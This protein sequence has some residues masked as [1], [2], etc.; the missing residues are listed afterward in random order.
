MKIKAIALSIG[1]AVATA[2]SFLPL[3][4]S[5]SN[6]SSARGLFDSYNNS[7][8][9]HTVDGRSG[10]TWSGGQ[11]SARWNRPQIDIIDIQAPSLSVGCGGIDFF[12]GAFGLI[13]GDELA[14]IGRAIAQGATVY[15][16]KLAINSICS[17]CAAEMENVAS[18]LRRF[19][20][21]SRNA[22]E[23]TESFLADN[24]GA[25]EG[26]K[27]AARGAIAGG[28]AATEGKINS[29]ADSLLLP[30]ENPLDSSTVAETA[31]GAFPGSALERVNVAADIFDYMGFNDSVNDQRKAA[32]VLMT[33]VGGFSIK[34]TEAPDEDSQPGVKMS[35]FLPSSLN[36]FFIPPNKEGN[37]VDIA[38]CTKSV[39][40]DPTC[41]AFDK[42]PQD[43]E[44]L[45]NVVRQ[46]LA[47]EKDNPQSG[48]VPRVRT[49]EGLTDTQRKFVTDFRIPYQN[50][51]KM[52]DEY[53][54]STDMVIDYIAIQTTIAITHQV[55]TA[56]RSLYAAVQS[57]M[58]NVLEGPTFMK[59]NTDAFNAYLENMKG[60]FREL[61]S[62]R[63]TVESQLG[64]YLKIAQLIQS[65]AQG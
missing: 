13:S 42:F 59:E 54:I 52:A 5:D 29:W 7:L 39:E 8:G 17:S 55:D 49:R 61:N 31:D 24:Y 53:D 15:F 2:A 65:R 19:N 58:P 63:E 35:R 40:E 41:I 30:E 25:G 10:R 28:L 27:S 60:V 57:D 22:C 16:F 45:Y 46:F 9:S 56:I 11:I 23:R 20:E 38:K 14:Q 64:N 21:L 26:S 44:S 37:K 3:T 18:A 50:Y 34:T 47:G 12:A 4:I 1:L 43:Y 33:F 48:I 51:L 62:Q 6:A 32:S 36:N